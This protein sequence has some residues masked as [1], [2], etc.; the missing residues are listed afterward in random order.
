MN[1]VRVSLIG[2]GQVAGTHLANLKRS[3]RFEIVSVA[4]VAQA[5]AQKR[6]KEFEIPSWTTDYRTILD[7]ERVEGVFVLTPP[8][9]HAEIAIAAMKAGKHVFCEKPLAR[10][11]EQCRQIV[12]ASKETGR[13]FLLGYPMRH[14]PD[15]ANLRDIILSGKLGRPVLFR[16]IWGL[17]KGSPSP[18]IHDA[19][20]GGGVVYEHTH[21]LDYVSSIFGPATKV[22]ATVS[23][24]KPDNTTAGDTFTAIIDFAGGDQAVWSESWAAAGFGW[25]PICVGRHVR[26]TLDVI[27]K[28]GSLHFPTAD[29]Q[30]VLSYYDYKKK[31]DTPTLQWPWET[32]WAVNV[33]GYRSELEH[34]Y[35]CV[36]GQTK[37]LCTAEDGLTAIVLA[38]AIFQSSRTGN[39]VLIGNV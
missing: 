18:A 31:L 32:D 6:A 27:G 39:P 21:W 25:E 30:K 10:T 12:R 16:D 1:P 4:D 38:E 36:R 7:D 2:C 8:S 22:Y 5:S 9:N 14:S 15:A 19:D 17:C 11:S 23:R 20:L 24:F 3:E 29:G 37:P 13:V 26:P 28:A 33:S 35:D 34:F